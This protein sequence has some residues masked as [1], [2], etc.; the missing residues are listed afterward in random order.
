MI[1]SHTLAYQTARAGARIQ[2]G[3]ASHDRSN[4]DD[5]CWRLESVAVGDYPHKPNKRPLKPP[6]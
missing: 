1:D 6:T 5:R 4:G 2:H 3:E